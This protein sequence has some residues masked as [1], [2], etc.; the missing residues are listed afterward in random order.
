[1]CIHPN[2]GMIYRYFNGCG[3]IEKR[4]PASGWDINYEGDIRR[5]AEF[6]FDGVKFDGC[7]K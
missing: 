6:G 2:P 1:M 5:L 7:V 4:E 3:C